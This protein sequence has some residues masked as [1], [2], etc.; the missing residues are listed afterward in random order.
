MRHGAALACSSTTGRRTH[1]ALAV[2]IPAIRSS[3]AARL[4]ATLRRVRALPWGMRTLERVIG[5]LLR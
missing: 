3:S 1:G 4:E 2:G 5:W